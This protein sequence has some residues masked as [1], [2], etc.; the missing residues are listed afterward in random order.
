MGGDDDGGGGSGGG[1]GGGGVGGGGRWQLSLLIRWQHYFG[2]LV[3]GRTDS[4]LLAIG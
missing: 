3:G 2:I 4:T 1:G